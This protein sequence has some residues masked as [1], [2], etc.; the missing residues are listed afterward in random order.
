M[1]SLDDILGRNS[2]KQSDFEYYEDTHD[3]KGDYFTRLSEFTRSQQAGQ[4]E[5]QPVV[6]TQVAVDSGIALNNV[7]VFAPVNEYDSQKIIDDV[8]K[9]EPVILNLENTDPDVSQRVLDFVSGATYALGGSVHKI[10][11][12]IF[13]VVPEKVRVMLSNGEN[14]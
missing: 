14:K 9:R 5:S 3:E 4:V 10:S 13:L 11:G 7:K 1:S 2:G 8:K 12:V 6:Q